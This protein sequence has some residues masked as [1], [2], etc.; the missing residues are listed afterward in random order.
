MNAEKSTGRDSDKIM[1]RVPDGMRDRIA[2]CAKV[3]NR[4]MN[5]EIVA[6]LQSSFDEQAGNASTRINELELELSK[7]R[8]CTATER[9]KAI[10]YSFSLMEMASC[11]P[12]GVFANNPRLEE[13]LKEARENRYAKM[14]EALDH[15][16]VDAKA[17]ISELNTNIDAGRIKF[18]D[19]KEGSDRKRSKQIEVVVRGK[20][21][22]IEIEREEP[23]EQGKLESQPQNKIILL[24]NLGNAPDV[25]YIVEQKTA[26]KG[27]TKRVRNKPP[28]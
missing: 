16:M 28:K 23:E 24:G 11:L 15:M 25:K 6:R 4:T 9:N 17:V 7:Q 22:V 1:L 10:Q 27:P 19:G 3:N 20:K 18:V 14:I 21:Q 5:A 13:F 8:G 26:N 2:A 12:P